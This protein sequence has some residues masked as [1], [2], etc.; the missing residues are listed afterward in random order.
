MLFADCL[1]T[2][3]RHS[4]YVMG[5]QNEGTRVSFP[6]A[7]QRWAQNICV[8]SISILWPCSV[9]VR[10]EHVNGWI[11]ITRQSPSFSSGPGWLTLLWNAYNIAAVTR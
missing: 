6:A 3:V 1:Q 9:S 4:V 10:E 7:V 5:E 11:I 8:W 2:D